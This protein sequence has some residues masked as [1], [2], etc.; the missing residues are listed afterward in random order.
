[1]QETTT[2]YVVEV[3][4]SLYFSCLFSA[5]WVFLGLRLMDKKDLQLKSP[6]TF[7][8]I[9]G[10]SLLLFGIASFVR[11]LFTLRIISQ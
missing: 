6:L 11:A 7:K 2:R 4:G 3:V 10:L 8:K 5:L 1:M 9:F